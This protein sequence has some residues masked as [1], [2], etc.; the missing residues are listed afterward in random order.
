MQ[1]KQI[2]IIGAGISGLL[3]CKYM[4][5]KGFD[6]I[7]FEARSDVGGVWIKTIASTKL[8][9][10]KTLYQLSDF[11]WPS[12]VTENFPAQHKVF[13]YTQS[14]A[15]HFDLIKH[16]R[17]NTKVVGIEYEGQ[18]DKEIQSCSLWNGNGQPFSFKGK[19]KVVVDN[20]ENNSTEV[21]KVD[22][23][24]LCLGRYCDVPNIPEFPPKKGPEAFHGKVIHSMDYAAMDY[25]SAA[26]FVEGKKVIVVGFQKSALDIAME[27]SAAN[28]LRNPCTALYRTEQWN[29]PANLSW[30]VPLSCLCRNRFSK[31]LARKP[32]EGFLLSLLATLLS[33]V[34]AFLSLL[35]FNHTPKGLIYLGNRS[36]ANPQLVV[37]GF[38]KSFSNLHIRNEMPLA[39][40]AT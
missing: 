33:P 22:F 4:L 37:I 36:S 3:A 24:I 25:E 13:D 9:T 1:R 26:N 38:S 10:P 20:T 28:G 27:C 31:L 23:V 35:S 30:G 29:V 7:V 34:V 16:I 15:Q 18:S 32:G 14:Y 12:S 2:G 6:P 40:R 11:P 8:Q 17:F 19:W 5:S 21:H 39:S